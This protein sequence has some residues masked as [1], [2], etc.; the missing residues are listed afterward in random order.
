MGRRRAGAGPRLGPECA[1]GAGISRAGGTCGHSEN[2]RCRPGDPADRRE[3]ARTVMCG[4]PVSR[5]LANLIEFGQRSYNRLLEAPGVSGAADAVGSLQPAPWFE[6]CRGFTTPESPLDVRLLAPDSRASDGPFGGRYL[7]RL[8]HLDLPDEISP[9]SGLILPQ[10]HGTPPPETR[11][12][13]RAT[14]PA[15]TKLGNPIGK[16]VDD[17]SAP[18]SWTLSRMVRQPTFEPFLEGC[19][20]AGDCRPAAALS[21]DR[22]LDHGPRSAG[23]NPSSWLEPPIEESPNFQPSARRA[24]AAIRERAKATQPDG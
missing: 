4:G 3:R 1:S 20:Q 8:A 23:R 16:R 13:A 7:G 11:I 22:G 6:E 9:G 17:R 2:A 19:R 14:L 12:A 24:L 5:R 21:L 10:N 15:A 18:A